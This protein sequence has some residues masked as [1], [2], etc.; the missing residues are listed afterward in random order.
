MSKNDTHLKQVNLTQEEFDALAYAVKARL[1]AIE[2]RAFLKYSGV[3]IRQYL[4]NDWE[5]TSLISLADKFGID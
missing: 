5:Y 2:K 4:D 3:A 1:V